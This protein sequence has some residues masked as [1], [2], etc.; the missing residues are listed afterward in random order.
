[1]ITNWYVFY[2]DDV[3]AMAK[4]INATAEQAFEYARNRWPA[5]NKYIFTLVD[6]QTFKCMKGL[7]CG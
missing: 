3:K 2:N 1:M 4:V 6:E 7:T 5:Y